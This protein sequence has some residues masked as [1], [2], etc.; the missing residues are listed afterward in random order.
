[1]FGVVQ[2][3][4]THAS[5]FSRLRDEFIG[6]ADRHDGLRFS[7]EGLVPGRKMVQKLLHRNIPLRLSVF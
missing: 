1:M 6:C 5:V 2:M 7:T 3:M 4:A